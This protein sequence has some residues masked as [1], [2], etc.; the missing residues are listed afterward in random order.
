MLLSMKRTVIE[1]DEASLSDPDNIV[2]RGREQ[3][4]RGVHKAIH[5]DPRSEQ[6]KKYS[7]IEKAKIVA[8]AC[9]SPPEGRKRWSI[10]PLVNEIRKRK[11]LEGMNRKTVRINL[12]KRHE[13]L[14]EK[15]VRHT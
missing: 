8:L 9:S 10:R 14:E 4:R 5:D 15:D 13:A 11:G 3:S 2:R 7:V 6:P 12:K 1:L